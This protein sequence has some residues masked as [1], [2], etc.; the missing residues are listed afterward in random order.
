MTY[1]AYLY[2]YDYPKN[3]DFLSSCSALLNDNLSRYF[4]PEGMASDMELEELVDELLRGGFSFSGQEG[5]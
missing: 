4:V 1:T 2:K 3:S 5:E